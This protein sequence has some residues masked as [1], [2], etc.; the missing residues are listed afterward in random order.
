MLITT[1]YWF[2]CTWIGVGRNF[3][4]LNLIFISDSNHRVYY[5]RHAKTFHIASC[6][7]FSLFITGRYL[8]RFNDAR[9]WKIKGKTVDESIFLVQFQQQV[10]LCASIKS[11][12]GPIYSITRKTKEKH[13]FGWNIINIVL[14]FN[15][16]EVQ[17]SCGMC[18]PFCFYFIAEDHITFELQPQINLLYF[19]CM[20]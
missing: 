4:Q 14:T 5:F 9:K 19:S 8:I 7:C 6:V 17:M 18:F 20:T 15:W 3:P 16:I 2:I 13:I 1:I 11:Y 12:F 10:Q